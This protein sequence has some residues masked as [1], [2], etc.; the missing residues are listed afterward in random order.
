MK[1]ATQ[2][3]SAACAARKFPDVRAAWLAFSR[4]LLIRRMDERD[5]QL[6]PRKTECELM[7]LDEFLTTGGL[8]DPSHVHAT[9][10]VEFE[11]RITVTVAAD[12]FVR[13]L[14]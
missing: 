2:I 14:E 13:G 1:T 6:S 3:L 8:D 12:A 9:W 11:R 4:W 7:T 5:L 10:F